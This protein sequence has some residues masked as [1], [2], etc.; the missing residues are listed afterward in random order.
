M[1]KIQL[2]EDTGEW[3]CQCGNTASSAG[4]HACLPDGGWTEPGNDWAGL[5]KCADCYSIIDNNGLILRPGYG[6]VVTAIRKRVDRLAHEVY[7]GREMPACQ[8]LA[9]VSN[10]IRQEALREEIE[11]EYRWQSS[12]M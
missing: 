6:A 2:E 3:I 9:L 12:R 10:I 5:Y 7:D 11:E 4:F 8:A 1:T